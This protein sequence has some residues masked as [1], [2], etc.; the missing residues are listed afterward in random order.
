M[1][2]MGGW[3]PKETTC[4]AKDVQGQ[5]NMVLGNNTVNK[6]MWDGYDPKFTAYAVPEVLVATIGGG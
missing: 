5:H 4:D 6:K 1:I 3:F 2:V